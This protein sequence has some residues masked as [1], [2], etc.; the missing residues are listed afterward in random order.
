MKHTLKLYKITEFDNEGGFMIYVECKIN[1]KKA[2]LIVDTGASRTL[3]NLDSCKE[4]MISDKNE[5]MDD[6]KIETKGIGSTNLT[7][8]PITIE[9]ISFNRLHIKNADAF[10]TDLSDIVEV[11]KNKAHIDGI[12][13]S[14]I[15]SQYS[16]VIDYGK[17][18]IRF[19]NET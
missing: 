15:L 11:L 7:S 5:D 10:A 2:N 18:T 17:N 4:L 6:I 14:D 16:S 3:I 19:I 8:K 12:M 1:H 13:G 9:E